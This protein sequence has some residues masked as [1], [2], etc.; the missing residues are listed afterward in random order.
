[1][2]SSPQPH[3]PARRAAANAEVL[4]RVRRHL[5]SERARG[6]ILVRDLLL[7]RGQTHAYGSDRSQR[8][9]LHLPRGA[10]PHPVIVLV[11]GGAWQRRYGRLIMRALAREAVERGL[12]AWNIEFRRLGNGGGWPHTFADVAAAIDFLARLDAPL[13]LERVSVLGHSSG[14]HL[15]LWAAA[16][17]RLPAGAPGAI[18]GDPRVRLRAAISL[19]GVCDLAGAYSNRPGAA[20]KALMGGSPQ[21]LPERYALADPLALVPLEMP[22][23]LVHGTD[24]ES[25]PVR[26]ARNFARA[27]AA[28]GAEVELVELD[29]P[30]GGHRAHIEPHSASWRTA[31][32]FLARRGLCEPGAARAAQAQ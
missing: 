4:K 9:D 8:T 26:L 24:D 28:A 31:G 18:E 17:T 14:G 23:L 5:A 20:V 10:G 29:G 19:A 25:V 6:A 15:A 3:E 21:G 30:D 16:R 1:M 11:H 2:S 27:S 13:D 32:E 22:V 12:A 7:A